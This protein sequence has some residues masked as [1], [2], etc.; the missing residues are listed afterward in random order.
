MRWK[1]VVEVTEQALLRKHFNALKV[2][3]YIMQT[4]TNQIKDFRAAVIF[5]IQKRLLRNAQFYFEVWGY[6]YISIQKMGLVGNE[7]IIVKNAA[8]VEKVFNI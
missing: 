2:S 4:Y 3:Q 5:Y 8:I 7:V 1:L 6:K